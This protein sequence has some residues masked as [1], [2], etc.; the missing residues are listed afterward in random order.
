MLFRK[1]QSF[2]LIRKNQRPLLFRKKQKR[3]P[4]SQETELP[5]ISQETELP[6]IS[7][8]TEL[9]TI[10]SY[11]FLSAMRH[12]QGGIV[13]YVPRISPCRNPKNEGLTPD[14]ELEGSTAVRA[15]DN[16]LKFV[17]R[18]LRRGRVGLRLGRSGIAVPDIYS[19]S[20]DPTISKRFQ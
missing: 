13:P 15:H 18:E 14:S 20:S 10:P 7:Q 6:T 12:R 5:T 17:K 2:P 19:R 1:E 8:E 11:S 16:V 4:I 9:P 3:H